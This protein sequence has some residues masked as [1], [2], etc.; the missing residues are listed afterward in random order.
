MEGVVDAAVVGE[1]D[2]IMGQAIRA[3][4]VLSEGTDYKPSEVTR[5]CAKKLEPFMVPKYVTILSEMQ[6]TTSNKI[7]KKNMKEFAR[8]KFISGDPIDLE[9]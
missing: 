9:A 1:D 2:K 3:Y 6:K 5:F 8:P 4:L 7:T